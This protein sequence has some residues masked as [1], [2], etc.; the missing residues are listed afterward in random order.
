MKKLIVRIGQAV[1]CCGCGLVCA[2]GASY[3]SNYEYATVAGW[4]GGWLMGALVSGV[5]DLAEERKAEHKTL[6]QGYREA[7]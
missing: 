5:F 6:S 1:F 7:A 4:F 2:I 3:V